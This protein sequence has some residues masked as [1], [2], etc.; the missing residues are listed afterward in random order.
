M[1]EDAQ[2]NLKRMF[3]L[4]FDGWNGQDWEFLAQQ[5]SDDVYVSIN[6]TVTKGLDV[7]IA[8]IMASAAGSS[9]RRITSHPIAFGSEDWTCV[10]S[11]L[12][13]GGQIVTVARWVDG[14]IAE[15]HIWM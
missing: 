7:H 8:A 12:S 10:V 3:R 14:K 2:D 9:D 1:T 6:G 13:D 4:D 5:H 15:E 11:D